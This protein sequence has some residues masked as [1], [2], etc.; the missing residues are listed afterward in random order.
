M[1]D[2]LRSNVF[3]R[4]P[5]ETIACACIHLA[6]AK[7]KVILPSNPPWY[8]LFDASLDDIQVRYLL[9]LSCE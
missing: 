9:Q 4:F 1:N 7:M 8:W 6:A 2:S 5:P 3:L